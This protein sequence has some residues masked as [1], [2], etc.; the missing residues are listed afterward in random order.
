MPFE[1]IRNDIT[2]MNV[3]AIVNAANIKLVAGG[4]VCG[5][6]FAAAGKD[7]LSEACSK[8]GYCEV[9]KAV[10]TSGYSLKAKFLI[11]TVG[12]VWNGGKSNEEMLLKSSYKELLRA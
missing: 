9:G 5:A 8:I 3:D 12:P 7:K 4:G 10:I 6:I 11:H 1:I 2:H